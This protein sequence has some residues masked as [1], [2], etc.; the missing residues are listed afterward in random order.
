ML[1]MTAFAQPSQTQ[2][3][4]DTENNAEIVFTYSNPVAN[5]PTMLHF[6]VSKHVSTLIPVRLAFINADRKTSSTILGK[7]NCKM[8]RHFPRYFCFITPALDDKDRPLLS[9]LHGFTWCL[10]PLNTNIYMT[11]MLII[12]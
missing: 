7:S 3:S 6:S 10:D 2:I 12:I 8:Q 11:R 9:T 4:T 5:T 1:L